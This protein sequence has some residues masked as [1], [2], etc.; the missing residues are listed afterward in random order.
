MQTS[1]YFFC[2]R[3]YNTAIFTGGYVYLDNHELPSQQITERH[4][5]QYII[6]HS[7]SGVICIST[8]NRDVLSQQVAFLRLRPSETFKAPHGSLTVYGSN[9]RS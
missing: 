1:K 8:L 4:V 5:C 7:K 9:D 2:R 6:H 3:G